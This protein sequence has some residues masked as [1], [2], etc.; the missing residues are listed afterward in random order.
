MLH[1]VSVEGLNLCS[2]STLR[3]ERNFSLIPKDLKSDVD[4][5]YWKCEA[6]LRKFFSHVELMTA[7]DFSIFILIIRH[8]ARECRDRWGESNEI[9]LSD[10]INIDKGTENKSIWQLQLKFNELSPHFRR[11]HHN[12]FID[13]P[14]RNTQKL[15]WREINPS[16]IDEF[17]EFL[18]T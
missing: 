14:R 5:I 16:E 10:N 18:L 3:R 17:I 6:F 1:H 12:W 2:F 11:Q 7:D 9:P 4:L 15:S 13:Q 8:V